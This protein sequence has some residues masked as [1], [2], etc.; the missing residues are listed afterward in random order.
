MERITQR[1]R[2]S[3]LIGSG[4][5]CG[6]SENA[7]PPKTETQKRRDKLLGEYR[8]TERYQRAKSCKHC[9]DLCDSFGRYL[10]TYCHIRQE[11]IAGS[12]SE[13]DKMARC[14]DCELYEKRR[15]K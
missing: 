8:K 10:S 13:P 5:A 2:L 7:V 11:H 9:T 15:V 1:A 6:C 4:R 14:F 12:I 3:C